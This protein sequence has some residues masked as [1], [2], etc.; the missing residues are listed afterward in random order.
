LVSDDGA[1][2]FRKSEEVPV[3]IR[4]DQEKKNKN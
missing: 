3:K 2:G 1:N 4:I